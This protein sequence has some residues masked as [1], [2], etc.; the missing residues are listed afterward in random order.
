M[1]YHKK[2]LIML[3]KVKEKY[4]EL[5]YIAID[6]DYYKILCSRFSVTSIPTVL[7]LHDG[8][9]VGRINGLVLTSAFKSTFSD[10]YNS[11]GENNAKKNIK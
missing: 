7:M 11:I 6:T 2:M 9:E 8:K 10:I 5:E 1:P 3:N 4:S